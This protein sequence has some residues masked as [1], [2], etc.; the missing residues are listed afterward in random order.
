[1]QIKTLAD[2]RLAL[3]RYYVQSRPKG[4]AYSLDHMRQ[5]LS[6]VGDPQNSL[7]IIH[8]AGTS[9]KTS[10]AYYAS[11]L[12]QS[13]GYSVGLTVSPHVVDIT[14]RVQING[15]PLDEAT[16]CADLEHFLHLVD[17]SGLTPTYFEVMIAFA[18]WEFA[19]KRVDYAVVEVGI[20]GLLDMTNV[21]ERKDK[22]CL[23][24]DIGFDHMSILGSTLAEISEQK[25]GI[26]QHLN[27]VCMFRQSTEIM[28]SVQQRARLKQ[29]QL[30]ILDD[31]DIESL[32][33]LPK[34]QRRNFS[35]AVAAVAI[36]LQR[37]EQQLTSEQRLQ[38]SRVHI[39]G[40]MEVCKVGNKTV[41]LD[42]AHNEQKI[43]ALIKGVAEQYPHQEVA[44]LVAFVDKSDALE[45]VESC[46]NILR[47]HIN[48]LVVTEFGGPRDA[49]YI[50]VASEIVAAY[51]K[52][53][54]FH[55]VQ[56]NPDPALAFEQ[57]L[58]MPQQVVVVT[59]SFYLLNHI[60]PLS[61]E[62]A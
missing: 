1:M 39:P 37:R 56:A 40:R 26:I 50:S 53:A 49:P 57:L 15:A 16:F 3:E 34:F 45:R 14:D 61:L 29:A 19:V 2:A 54:G 9:G 36:V 22:V 24:T 18:F 28:N 44:A 55:S 47:P 41:I 13:A 38:A 5:L 4:Q 6:V 32:G 43:D 8:V 62:K 58:E 59:G 52:T 25:A 12:L 23:I 17:R 31:S 48:E 46:L 11:A 33:H 51:A 10:T 21:I 60:R 7:H 27:E 35:L 42:G 30:H 20:G